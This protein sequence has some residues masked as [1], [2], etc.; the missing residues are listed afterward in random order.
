MFILIQ[1][2]YKLSKV[3]SIDC[4]AASLFDCI[5]AT[6]TKEMLRVYSVK[7]VQFAKEVQ[8][9]QKKVEKAEKRVEELDAKI[10]EENLANPDKKVRLSSCRRT[11][12][13]SR[14]QA[15]RL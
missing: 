8:D 11:R 14:R 1:F 10:K 2:G 4:L 6:C 12:S 3:F 15:S 13:Q 7:E 9:R 5:W